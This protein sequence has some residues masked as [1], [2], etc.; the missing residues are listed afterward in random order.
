M[1][2]ENL[3]NILKRVSRE[4]LDIR[5]VHLD[6]LR[7]NIRIMNELN[8]PYRSDH[9][10]KSLLAKPFNFLNKKQF[11][12]NDYLRHSLQIIGEE[13][14]TSFNDSLRRRHP[15][16][17]P[18]LAVFVPFDFRPANFGG[19]T[20]IFN[21]Y[22][23]LSRRFVVNAVAIA[24]YGT[25]S[26]TKAYN[27]NFTVHIVPHSK[28]YADLKNI[29][30]RR[31]RGRLHDILLIDRYPLI[32]E[33]VETTTRLSYHTDCV[34]A[35]HPFTFNMLAETYRNALLVYEAHNIEAD[36]KES[37][38]AEENAINRAYLKKVRDAEERACRESD[39]IFSVSEEDANHIQCNFNVEADKIVLAENGVDARKSTFTCPARRRFLKR[40]LGMTEPII[41]FVGSDHG[42]NV[43]AVD[44]IIEELAPRDENIKYVIGGSII[45]HYK[46]GG[47]RKTIPG[48]VQFLGILSE[49]EKEALYSIG[50]L[51]VNPIFSGSGTNLKIF[52]YGAHG[53]PIL[54][55]AFGIRGAPE[56]AKCATLS[57]RGA[58][59]DAI[60]G[61]LQKS[62]GELREMTET[63]RRIV[64]VTY[65][66]EVIAERMGHTIAGLLNGRKVAAERRR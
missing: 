9:F 66:W 22:N 19:A 24:D 62:D 49:G 30:E 54:S 17:T 46:A 39:V 34:I 58:F 61:I 29:E 44:F 4:N 28:E 25:E 55:T 31:A 33:L 32:P 23:N 8:G 63:C 42:P 1:E 27:D 41:I 2:I 20:R 51:A 45:W 60:R 38:F 43:E 57:E 12:I 48:N 37:Y 65:D 6:Q 16:G 11:Q 15:A 7:R 36:L 26:E 52:D 3:K 64:E 59:L 47:E 35:S 50:D 13:V 40:M 56:L 53:L 10:L 5:K 21:I 14:T 18:R